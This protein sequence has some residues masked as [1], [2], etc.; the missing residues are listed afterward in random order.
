MVIETLPDTQKQVSTEHILI[1][2]VMAINNVHVVEIDMEPFRVNIRFKGQVQSSKSVD[3]PGHLVI[4][5]RPP[6]VFPV[7]YCGSHGEVLSMQPS[8]ATCFL[9]ATSL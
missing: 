9:Q 3:S 7:Q 2:N 4:Y 5:A 6:T 8:L 1:F